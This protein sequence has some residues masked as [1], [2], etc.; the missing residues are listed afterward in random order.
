MGKFLLGL[1]V[2][3]VLGIFAMAV[4]PDLP[5]EI[6]VAAASLTALVM[7]GAEEAAEEVGAAADRVAEEADQAIDGAA[8]RADEAVE[9]PRQ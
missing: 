5:R 8:E 9:E 2:G 7:R 3:V 1:I 6:R 4:N